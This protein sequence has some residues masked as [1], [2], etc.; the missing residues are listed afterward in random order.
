MLKKVLGVTAIVLLAAAGVAVS[1]VSWR[2]AMRPAPTITVERTAQQVARGQYLSEHVLTCWG[3]HNARDWTRWGGPISGPRGE[4]GTDCLLRKNG[5]GGTVCPSNVT[6]D[7]ETGIG[8]WTDGEI[9][10]ALREGVDRDGRALFPFMPFY[11]FRRMSDEDTYAVVAYLRA[12]PAVRHRLPTVEFD[13]KQTLENNKMPRPVDGPVPAI[14]PADHVRYGQYLAQLTGCEFC[15]SPAGPDML[16]L[17]GK[18]YSGGVEFFETWGVVRTANITPHET[19]IKGVTRAEF[20]SRFKAF[21]NIPAVAVKPPDPSRNTIMPWLEFSGMTE[22]D[23]GDIYDFL[24]T[25]P[26]IDHRVEKYPPK[27][28]AAG[29]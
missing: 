1:R 3:C 29:H 17:A 18:L 27:V 6:P 2:P 21:A 7:P 12:L 11:S 28:A 26:P 23:L 16:P 20:I 14:D 9:V 15:H 19:G 4:G 8:T 10:R 22:E 25:V 13:F 5:F 24:Q